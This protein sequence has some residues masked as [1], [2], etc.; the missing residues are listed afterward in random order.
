MLWNSRND[1]DIRMMTLL[2]ILRMMLMMIKS[3][4]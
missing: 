1:V 2:R 3:C 4:K